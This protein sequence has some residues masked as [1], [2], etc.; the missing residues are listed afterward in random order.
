M[1]SIG[2]YRRGWN[3]STARLEW[4]KRRGE[5]VACLPEGLADREADELPGHDIGERR[6]DRVPTLQRDGFVES[7]PRFL[8]SEIWLS[9]DNPMC[10]FVRNPVYSEMSSSSG[11]AF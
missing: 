2:G 9:P 10:A 3:I 6:V 5:G 8:S 7:E 11:N 4:N 1:T